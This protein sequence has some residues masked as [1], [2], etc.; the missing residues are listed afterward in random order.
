[1]SWCPATNLPHH[2]KPQSLRVREGNM[3]SAQGLLP[4][5]GEVIHGEGRVRSRDWGNETQADCLHRNGFPGQLWWVGWEY[6]QSLK[7][8]FIHLW[9]KS[10]FDPSP[11]P[12]THHTPNKEDKGDLCSGTLWCTAAFLWSWLTFFCRVLLHSQEADACTCVGCVCVPPS[13]PRT[14]SCPTKLFILR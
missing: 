6:D 11:K 9:S 1:M 14:N 3:G 4:C 2:R 5:T 12:V 13:K 7:Y 10:F 8:R